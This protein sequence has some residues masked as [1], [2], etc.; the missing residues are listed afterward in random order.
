MKTV[1]L[2][3]SGQTIV[4]FDQ[5]VKADAIGLGLF[6]SIAEGKKYTHMADL[7][8]IEC[9]KET[10]PA[11]PPKTN[12][13]QTPLP[14]KTDLVMDTIPSNIPKATT[15]VT[16]H[17]AATGTSLAPL[18]LIALG[19]IATGALGLAKRRTRAL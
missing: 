1:T 16:K 15:P 9:P 5:P 6:N 2:N 8:L 11:D 19:L 12:S 13:P 14:P 7:R 4:K 3:A 17:L 18:A 10:F